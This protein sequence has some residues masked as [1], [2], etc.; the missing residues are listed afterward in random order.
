MTTHPS[1]TAS[2][3]KRADYRPLIAVIAE[4]PTV[5]YEYNPHLPPVLRFADDPAKTDELPE[6]LR[7][8]KQRPLSDTEARM[9]AGARGETENRH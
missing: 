7:E 9:L 8:A 2:K 4:S 1:F 3:T 6:L 5:R